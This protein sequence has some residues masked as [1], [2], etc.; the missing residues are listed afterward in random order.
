ME[1]TIGNYLPL[2]H[3]MH[4]IGI[5]DWSNNDFVPAELIK[6]KLCPNEAKQIGV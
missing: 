1:N 5:K 2:S 6:K 3:S 4:G